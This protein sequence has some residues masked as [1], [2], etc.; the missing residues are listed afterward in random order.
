MRQRVRTI[1]HGSSGLVASKGN[2]NVVVN[3][4]LFDA[5]PLQGVSFYR[6]KSLDKNGKITYS[7]AVK[8][9]LSSNAK[10]AITVS[11]NPVTGN[12]V[13]IQLNLPKGTYTLTL[14]NKL[15]QQL[16]NKVIQHAGGNATETLKPSSDF[17]AGIYQL[18]IKGN[19]LSITEQVIKK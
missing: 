7:I 2:S 11:P 13:A 1:R 8:V 16:A 14:T 19:G 3:Y 10:N 17:A 4:D 12:N 6:I 15:G 9:T 18:K 5:A